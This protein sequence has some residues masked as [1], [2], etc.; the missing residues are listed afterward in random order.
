[1]EGHRGHRKL[2]RKSG[3]HNHHT[4]NKKNSK[5]LDNDK[6]GSK[7][8]DVNKYI[9]AS[10]IKA[11]PDGAGGGA[12]G[13][14]AP[15]G[16]DLTQL[17]KRA[18]D[19]TGAPLISYNVSHD[20]EAKQEAAKQS[21][22]R[23]QS[24]SHPVRGNKDN[25]LQQIQQLLYLQQLQ[26]QLQ[27]FGFITAAA[28][29]STSTPPP[30][31][32]AGKRCY[33]VGYNCDSGH[34][35]LDG[36]C[37]GSDHDI[38]TG[39]CDVSDLCVGASSAKKSL[40]AANSMPLLPSYNHFRQDL[41][42]HDFRSDETASIDDLEIEVEDEQK[43]LPTDLFQDDCSKL[44]LS[45]TKSLMRMMGGRGLTSW[46]QDDEDGGNRK[47]GIRKTSSLVVETTLSSDGFT[48]FSDQVDLLGSIRSNWEK[49]STGSGS[50]A[51]SCSSADEDH[52]GPRKYSTSSVDSCGS[53]ATDTSAPSKKKNLEAA[54]KNLTYDMSTF[55]LRKI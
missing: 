36:S 1:M 7:H 48:L 14:G 29:S 22:Y 17:Q 9:G 42:E 52:E 4:F 6:S 19:L 13:G 10:L 5:K 27:P 41:D 24:L 33:E 38:G 28:A 31:A 45:T 49:S 55:L 3:Y 50:Q 21:V 47:Q 54:I 46:D 2:E 40:E 15:G 26:Q 53:A 8:S 18:L 12:G 25:S 23:T 32:A 30:P 37:C 44:K 39:S 16:P 20:H 34:G 43:Y 51:S 11:G 35:S